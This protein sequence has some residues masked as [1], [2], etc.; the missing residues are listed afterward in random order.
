[1]GS[2]GFPFACSKKPS[3]SCPPQDQMDHLHM[4]QLGSFGSM[5][6]HLGRSELL[7]SREE[8]SAECVGGV[9]GLRGRRG[10]KLQPTSS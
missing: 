3:G 4:D 5:S 2:D 1:M 9:R 7:F 8:E 10:V 6:H